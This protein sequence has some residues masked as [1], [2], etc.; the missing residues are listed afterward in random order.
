[1]GTLQTLKNLWIGPRGGE[2]WLPA[3]KS[4]LAFTPVG[5]MA[6]EA[7]AYINGGSSVRRSSGT[8]MEY[9]M[10]W[11][12]MS[13]LTLSP[14]RDMYNGSRGTGPIYFI[15]PAAADLNV[16]P[17]QWAYPASATDDGIPIIGAVRPGKVVTPSNTFNHPPVSAQY[18]LSSTLVSRSLY[19]PIP[20]GFDAWFGVT[21]SQTGT[22]GVRI[23][24]V[25][26][27]ST[28][29]AAI[30]P[31]ML[32]VNSGVRVNTQILGTS[33]AGLI[34][35][36]DPTG[37]ATSTTLTSMCCQILS[38]GSTPDAGGFIGGWGHSGCDFKATPVITISN[39]ALDQ[40]TAH[41]EFTEV[42]DWV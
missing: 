25:I 27:G 16:L 17:A 22:K 8:H 24:P 30:Y 3:P 11:G 5:W 9:P 41:A 39:A 42:G 20:P 10:D 34:I 4:G 1:M 12:L 28:V 19:I 13:R 23:T 33:Y 31:S 38:T 32:S 18:A 15:D 21:G 36:I 29:G 2:L 40:V 37:T 26:Q 14:L 7:N 35:D 6:G